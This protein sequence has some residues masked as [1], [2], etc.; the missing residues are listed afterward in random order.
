MENIPRTREREREQKYLYPH[1]YFSMRCSIVNWLIGVS[2]GNKSC[3]RRSQWLVNK[4]LGNYH[5]FEILIANYRKY[6]F[7]SNSN[8]YQSHNSPESLSRRLPRHC[9]RTFHLCCRNRTWSIVSCEING[10]IT[11]RDV[12][13]IFKCPDFTIRFSWQWV[14]FLQMKIIY[15]YTWIFTWIYLDISE[16]HLGH[17]FISATKTF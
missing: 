7:L 4:T 1:K 15:V 8:I 10:L 11:F 5:A 17:F 6:R 2:Q 13:W 12:S 3:S 14:L 9:C 16:Q